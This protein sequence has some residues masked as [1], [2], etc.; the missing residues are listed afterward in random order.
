[1]RAVKEVNL[2]A[3]RENYFSTK[4]LVGKTKITCVVKADAYGHGARKIA[5]TLADCEN[6]AVATVDEAI[7]LRNVAADNAE[8]LILG[9]VEENDFAECVSRN[10][11][12]SVDS[13]KELNSLNELCFKMHKRV[14]VH[15]ALN[16][17]M[18]RIGY[19]YRKSPYKLI[20]YA[21][22]L[23]HVNVSGVFTHIYDC[24][25]CD[26]EEQRKRFDEA[27]KSCKLSENTFRHVAAT[28]K[29][30]D[31]NFR[32]DMVRLGIGLYGYGLDFVIPAMS[33]KCR[34]V[35]V[36]QLIAG[37]TVGY[38][39]LFKAKK[40]LLC[41][42]LSIG[43]ADGVPRNYHGDV[44]I[45]GKRRKIV[46]S[47]CMDMCFAIV[48]KEVNVGDEAVL[49]GRQGKEMITAE[50]IADRCKT[51]SYEILTG[52][53]RMKTEYVFKNV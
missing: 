22:S 21:Y 43:Y 1:M 53:K 42:T 3:I 48:G 23:P 47:I 11:S 41:A 16:T 32:Y 25:S 6:F 24:G 50:E 39:G 28:G 14:N 19:S 36:N 34:V 4:S 7:E 5:E 38:G 52:F 2:N 18:N 49:L 29:L 46:G 35:A 40:P 12:L 30:T 31:K 15:I 13:Y 8:I 37:D 27:L 44:L 10:I 17:G 26:A 20:N 9:K 45:S 33:V 51:I